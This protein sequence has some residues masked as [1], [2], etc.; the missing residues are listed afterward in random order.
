MSVMV[1]QLNKVLEKINKESIER[2]QKLGRAIE[3]VIRQQNLSGQIGAI[4]LQKEILTHSYEKTTAY[5]NLVMIGGYAGMFAIWQLMK[6]HFSTSEELMIGSLMAASILL[7]AAHEVYKMISQALFFRRLNKVL[8][9]EVSDDERGRG[10]Q[11]AWRDN[12][13][14][15]SKIWIYFLIPTL[16]T[17]FGSG[18]LILFVFLRALRESV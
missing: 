3:S 4:Q 8:S 16:L 13:V 9:S 2:D 10:Y 7:F 1:D 6:S 17:G 12:A 15:E 11:I 5:T 14:M 18:L